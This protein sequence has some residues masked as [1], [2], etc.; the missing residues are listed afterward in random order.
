MRLRCCVCVS[1]SVCLLTASGETSLP[2]TRP[3]FSRAHGEPSR[4]AS[5]TFST[6][7]ALSLSLSLP[8]VLCDPADPQQQ[9]LHGGGGQQVRLQHVRADHHEPRGDHVYPSLTSRC[10][11]RTALVPDCPVGR[12]TGRDPVDQDSSLFHLCWSPNVSA[13]LG[14]SEIPGNGSKT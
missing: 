14:P 10:D 3:A 4:R 9:P 12:R 1:L 13:V 11:A 5:Q 2:D 7:T 8:Q 6:F